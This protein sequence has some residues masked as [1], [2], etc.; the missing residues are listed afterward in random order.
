MTTGDDEMQIKNRLM[1]LMKLILTAAMALTLAACSGKKG[2]SKSDQVLLVNFEGMTKLEVEEWINHNNVNRDQVFYAY[3][4]SDTIQEGRIIRQSIAAGLPLGEESLTITISNGANPDDTVQLPDFTQMTSE[5]IQKWFINEGFTNVKVEYVNS[6]TVEPGHFVGINVEGNVAR[7]NQPIVIQLAAEKTA[8]SDPG[9]KMENMSGWTREQVEYWTNMNMVN[10]DY[11][12]AR[13]TTVAQGRVISFSPQAGT[14]VAKGGRIQ[15]V[16]SMGSEVTAIDLTKMNRA[17]IE[18]WGKDNSIQISW[19]QCWNK[20]ASG[21]IFNNQPNS[22]IMRPGDI[23]YVYMS[24]GPIPVKDYT[25]LNYQGNFLGWLN[26][27]N[28]QYNSTANLKVVISEKESDKNNGTI[29]SQSPNSGYINPGE[30]IKLVIAKRKP[31]PTPT[32]TPKPTAKPTPTPDPVVTIPNMTGMSEYDF[33]HSLHAY[34]VWE[35]RR[36]ES[37]SKIIA[38]DYILWNETGEFREGESVDYEVSLGEFRI[39]PDE[40]YGVPYDRLENYIESANRFGAGID[41]HASMIDVGDPTMNNCVLQIMGP[42]D[43]GSMFVR[44]GIYSPEDGEEPYFPEEDEEEEEH[45]TGFGD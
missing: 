15:V 40:W 4:Y 41:L 29:L 31:A 35:G 13:S 45:E 5:Q 7:R 34:G 23:M 22:G 18:Q 10:C 2:D 33:K 44:V 6:T 30:T 42:E 38:K 12:Y 3:E 11:G 9:V 20:T 24:V 36:T 43:D 27:I 28:S 21:T 1:I 39:D 25:N 16:L 17:Q 19:V 8:P 32:P 14:S 37:Y 26:S